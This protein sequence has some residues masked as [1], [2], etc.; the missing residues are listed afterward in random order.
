MSVPVWVLVLI[1]VGCFGLLVFGIYRLVLLR[2]TPTYVTK[3]GTKVWTNNLPRYDQPTMET[4]QDAILAAFPKHHSLWT[5]SAILEVFTGLEINV[6]PYPLLYLG[7]PFDGLTDPAGGWINIGWF[8]RIWLSALCHEMGH[9][10]Y[11]RIDKVT[12]EASA[13]HSGAAD[14]NSATAEANDIA[15][16]LLAATQY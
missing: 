10:F 2:H 6:M 12:Y 15:S 9:V 4:M 7:K 5:R 14:A 11:Q 3:Y 8:S 1:A 13:N 16:K